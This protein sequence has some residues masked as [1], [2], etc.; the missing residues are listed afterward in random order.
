VAG[1]LWPESTSDRSLSSLR[2]VLC[3]MPRTP[4]PIVQASA[5]RLDLTSFVDVDVHRAAEVA[6]ALVDGRVPDD[7]TG[8]LGLLSHDLLADWA[9]DWLIIEQ[10]RFR[11]VRLLGLEALAQ[12]LLRAGRPAQAVMAALQ[13]L[14]A[15]P[16]RESAQ[17]LLMTAYLADGNRHEAISLYHRCAHLLR[18][19]LGLD[20]S[21]EMEA[22]L[23]SALAFTPH[24]AGVTVA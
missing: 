21:R 14:A 12:A 2:T 8:T 15:D 4:T 16:L 22:M 7:L 18:D 23:R 19:E 10:E 9:E 5:S 13:V 6:V 11:Q 24:D 1:T 20:P 17:R 3:A